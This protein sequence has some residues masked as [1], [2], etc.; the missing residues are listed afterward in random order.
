MT[1]LHR[2]GSPRLPLTTLALCPALF[3]IHHQ[4]RS[5]SIRDRL[6]RDTC[7]S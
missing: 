2:P 6:V 5:Y 7:S 1:L 3:G 4:W